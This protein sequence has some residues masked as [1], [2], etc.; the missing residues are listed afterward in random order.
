M[1]KILFLLLITSLITSCAVNRSLKP[2]NQSAPILQKEHQYPGVDSTVVREALDYADRMLVDAAQVGAADSLYYRALST[3][4]LADTLLAIQAIAGL[5]DSLFL[6]LSKQWKKQIRF[7]QRK[8]NSFL[9]LNQR[10][11][12]DH[13]LELANRDASQSKTLNPFSLSTRGLLVQINMK[14]GDLSGENEYYRV[15]VEEINNLLLVDKSNAD[16]Y[17]ELAE[18]YFAL[19]DWEKSYV[20]FK[21]AENVLQAISQFREIENPGS[22][23]SVDTAKWVYLLRGQGE[24]RAKLYDAEGA[25]NYL[26][27]AQNLIP[28]DQVKKQLDNYLAWIEWD[29]GNIR[30]SEIR[31]EVLKLESA[32][33]QKKAKQKYLELLNLLRTQRTK[34]EINW[35]IASIDYKYLNNELEAVQRLFGVVKNIDK[36][37]L[38]LEVNQF[39][40]KDYA[41]MCFSIGNKY[42]ENKEMRLAYIYLRQ[43]TKVNWELQAKCYFQLALLS[44]SNPDETIRNCNF[45]LKNRNQL[46]DDEVKQINQML[47]SAHKQNGEFD[48]ARKFFSLNSTKE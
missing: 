24:A 18:C 10:E 8:Y 34:N 23:V 39:Y 40:L 32:G 45:A 26:T 19:G 31:D 46:S 2:E 12:I 35:K 14:H 29:D 6:C 42:Y 37:D 15:A 13:L 20:N 43:A 36:N 38:N 27:R 41:A 25:I 17:T 47:F 33:E 22:R 28:S 1:R 3:F 21:Q 5:N 30:A 48:L 9:K 4:E 44:Q 11:R 7:P 16:V